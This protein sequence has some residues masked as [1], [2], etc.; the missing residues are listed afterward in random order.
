MEAAK[1]S[2]ANAVASVKHALPGQGTGTGGHT[3]GTHPTS[4]ANAVASAK[5]ALPGHGTGGH[6]T[7]TH[8]TSALPGHGTGTGGQSTAGKV[9]ER[10]TGTNKA[11]TGRHN[12][13]NY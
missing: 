4:A 3:T 2:A 9:I 7:G 6:T 10:V 1:H 13:N 12:A 11:G 8:P 5:H